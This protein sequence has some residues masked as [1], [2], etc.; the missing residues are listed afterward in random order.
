MN[1]KINAKLDTL[2]RKPGVYLFKDARAEV[3]YIGKAKNLFER[4]RTYFRENAE[5]RAFVEPMREEIHDLEF[6]VTGSEKEAFILENEMIRR[7]K[8]RYNVRLREGGNFVYLRLDV[9]KDYPRLEVTRQVRDDGA[10][11][12][13]PYPAATALRKTLRVINRYFHLRTCSDHD[14]ST[15]RQP[16]LL[17]QI[18]RFPQPSVFDI[19]KEDY[20]RYVEMAVRFLEGRTTGLIA[21]LRQ[22]MKAAAEKRNFE[23]AARLRDQIHA[24]ERTMEPQKIV[25]KDRRDRD[26]FGVHRREGRTGVYVLYVRQGRVIGGQGFAPDTPPG[27]T[28]AGTGASGS[29]P[30]TRGMTTAPCMRRSADRCSEVCGP[31]TCRI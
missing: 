23:E 19:P 7:H 17:C 29:V 25:S 30:W 21:D 5:D 6:I 31:M 26:V 4:V 10:R 9:N 1:A 2:A 15:H 11:Y 28:R 16:C 20:R 24:I 12:F 13:G 18:S 8:P 22:R 3:I 27:W 14:P